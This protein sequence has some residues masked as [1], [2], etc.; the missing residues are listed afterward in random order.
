MYQYVTFTLLPDFS[1]FVVFLPVT[2]TDNQKL[3]RNSNI[4][5]RSSPDLKIIQ[6]RIDLGDLALLSSTPVNIA[7]KNW[8]GLQFNPEA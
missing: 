5:A 7:R 4:E 2:V 1:K 8:S 3:L 6:L